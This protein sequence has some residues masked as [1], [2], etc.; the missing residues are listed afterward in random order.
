MNLNDST[1]RCTGKDDTDFP[2]TVCNKGTEGTTSIECIHREC[3]TKSLNYEQNEYDY[4][5][6]DDEE[7]EIRNKRSPIYEYSDFS[8]HVMYDENE[9]KINN[10]IQ[11]DSNTE[12]KSDTEEARCDS[13]HTEAKTVD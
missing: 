7:P 11:Q 12:D 6:L 1:G 4:I 2:C 5:C 13:L 9:H 8:L 3:H 10:K